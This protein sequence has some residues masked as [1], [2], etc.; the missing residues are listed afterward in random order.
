[1]TITAF[2]TDGWRW[3]HEPAAWSATDGV[4]EATTRPDSDFWRTTHYGFIRDNGHVLGRDVEGDFT[5]TATFSGAYRD[6]YDQAGVMLR[7]DEEN[8][9]KTGIELVD[10]VRQLSA[11]VTRGVSD[12]SVVPLPAAPASVTLAVE[13]R[14]D[15]VT[16][17]YGLDGGEPATMLRLA[18]FPPDVGVLAGVMCASPDGSGFTARFEE[19]AFR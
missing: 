3:L 6:L 8:W 4:V 13:R 10:G 16:V 1:M 7:L 17:R 11:V 9:V 19:V 5:L 14:G 15:T 18:Y 2:G 12:W